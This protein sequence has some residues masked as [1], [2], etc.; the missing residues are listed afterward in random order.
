MKKQSIILFLFLAHITSSYSAWYPKTKIVGSFNDVTDVQFDS[1][2]II[3]STPAQV[4]RWDIEAGKQIDSFQNNFKGDSV[5]NNYLGDKD[6]LFVISQSGERKLI[7]LDTKKTAWQEPE[8]P[9]MFFG[10]IDFNDDKSKILMQCWKTG[11]VVD[12]LNG[13]IQ[14]TLWDSTGQDNT[15]GTFAQFLPKSC[16]IVVIHN[17]WLNNA[18]NN[19]VEY[20]NVVPT[21]NVMCALFSPESNKLVYCGG[22]TI[23]LDDSC[24][25][26]SRQHNNISHNTVFEENK[27]DSAYSCVVDMITGKKIDIKGRE[28]TIQMFVSLQ[29]DG[30]KLLC[31]SY[32]PYGKGDYKNCYCYI[33]LFNLEE[34]SAE[35]ELAIPCDSEPLCKVVAS[36]KNLLFLGMRK[37]CELW[38][39]ALK[40]LLHS[41]DMKS[42]WP[43]SLN[44]NS[45]CNQIVIVED[46]RAVVWQKQD[47]ALVS[48][49]QA[50]SIKNV[51]QVK[52][53]NFSSLSCL[54][55]LLSFYETLCCGCCSQ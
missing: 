10:K 9:K 53:N 35:P 46:D 55:A 7:N 1:S 5:V 51:N 20:K 11:I 32:S 26:W 36:S 21:D 45:D 41:F 15:S 37:K 43:T 12:A 28:Y 47:K 4:S 27:D 23:A 24:V 40:T 16:D 25:H 49:H 48:M 34:A 8:N 50:S 3:M 22:G 38:D 14:T 39:T 6:R 18:H 33:D 30:K 42:E 52:Y 17:G 44:M 29:D 2:K 13:K 31:S 19:G 54:K